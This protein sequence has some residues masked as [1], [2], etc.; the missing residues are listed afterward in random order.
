MP[1]FDALQSSLKAAAV[2]GIL[3]V[4][5]NFTKEVLKLSW[6]IITT[7]PEKDTYKAVSKVRCEECKEFFIGDEKDNICFPCQGEFSTP[8]KK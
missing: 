4:W 7:S 2:G 3:M 5:A 6:H 1:K 8:L